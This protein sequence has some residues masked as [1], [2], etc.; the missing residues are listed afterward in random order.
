MLTR[1]IKVKE[2]PVENTERKLEEVNSEK[3]QIGKCSR[4]KGT[5]EIH[6]KCVKINIK[7]PWLWETAT[8]ISHSI[9]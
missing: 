4:M 8:E 9:L 7:T 3:D 1:V 5:I 6:E 2:S